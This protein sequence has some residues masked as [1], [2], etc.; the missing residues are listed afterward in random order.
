MLKVIACNQ[1]SDTTSKSSERT[2]AIVSIVYGSKIVKCTN[3]LKISMPRSYKHLMTGPKGNS[4]FS[5]SS[6]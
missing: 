2:K 6:H 1:T 4:E 3:L 5:P